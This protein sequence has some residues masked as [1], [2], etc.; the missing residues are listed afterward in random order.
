MIKVA[1]IGGGYMGAGHVRAY[2]RKKG[3]ELIAVCDPNEVRGR[4]LAKEYGVRWLPDYQTILEE[5]VDAVS[6]AV[7]TDLHCRVAADFLAEGIPV[8][9]EKPIAA[10]IEEGEALVRLSRKKAVPLQ[11]GHIERFN[12]AVRKLSAELRTP[13]Y[14]EIHRLGPFKGRG[15]EVSVVADLMIHDIDLVLDLVNSEMPGITEIAD[16]RALGLSAFTETADIATARITFDNGV[17]AN[18][19]ASRI[20]DK[21]MRKVRV[22]EADRYWSLDCE[23]QE[24][25]SYH[26]NPAGSWRKKERPTIEDLIVRETIPIEKA[27]PLSLEIDSFLKAVKSGEEPEVSGEDGVAALKVAFQIEERIKKEGKR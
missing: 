26:K 14:L 15:I 1:V 18:L 21:S 22:F 11:I 20:S 25:I 8:L 19:T 27:E 9:L 2:T 24:L 13:K 23:H 6:V 12:P 7:P 3:V 17:V 4:V 5:R 10:T 16:I